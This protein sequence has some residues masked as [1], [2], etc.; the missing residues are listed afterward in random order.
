[1]QSCGYPT[2]VFP[3]KQKYFCVNDD[4]TK[5][6]VILQLFLFA[7]RTRK[8][9]KMESEISAF[10]LCFWVTIIY[11]SW[12]YVLRV[13]KCPIIFDLFFVCNARRSR[14]EGSSR[15]NG[16]HLFI[17]VNSL[18]SFPLDFRDVK[19]NRI[20]NKAFAFLSS[21]RSRSHDG[22]CVIEIFMMITH[23][24]DYMQ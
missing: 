14:V 9:L 12:I 22:Y 4:G 24:P 19:R 10:N 3:K 21:S 8:Q 11:A 6:K 16:K 5:L 20:S 17:D 7:D 2:R 13:R 18:S 23:E 1:M 15:S